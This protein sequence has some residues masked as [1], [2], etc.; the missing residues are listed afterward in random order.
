MNKK[1]LQKQIEDS[2]E[3]KVGYLPGIMFI[4]SLII[5][6]IANPLSTYFFGKNSTESTVVVFSAVVIALIQLVYMIK[7]MNKK[8]KENSLH[9]P[10]CNNQLLNMDL[11]LIMI[12]NKCPYC[13]NKIVESENI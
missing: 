5:L 7:L 9:C 3:L 10:E 12:S 2:K 13:G 6:L 4:S 11:K 1:L 8:Q